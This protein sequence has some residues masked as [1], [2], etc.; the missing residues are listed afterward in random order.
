MKP[1]P[2]IYAKG[3]RATFTSE[4]HRYVGTMVRDHSKAHGAY[5][6]TAVFILEDV[7]VQER[8]IYFCYKKLKLEKS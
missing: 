2:I 6:L 3:Q 5:L 8:E 7:D 1:T 4:Y